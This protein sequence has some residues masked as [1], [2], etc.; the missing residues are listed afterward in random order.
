[1]TEHEEL[2]EKAEVWI[3]AVFCD[4]TVGRE[5]NRDSLQYLIE[6]CQSCIKAIECDLERERHEEADHRS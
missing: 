2:V 4:M 3:D 6:H 5:Q 1:M